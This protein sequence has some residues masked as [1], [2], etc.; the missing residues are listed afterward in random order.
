MILSGLC[1]RFLVLLCI[2]DQGRGIQHERFLERFF[3]L[4]TC[5]LH[6]SGHATYTICCNRH[7]IFAIHPSS[8]IIHQS[9]IR[10][11]LPASIPATL[12]THPLAQCSLKALPLAPRPLL[13][14][15]LPIF[16][17]L[18]PP[19]LVL[20]VSYVPVLRRVGNRPIRCGRFSDNRN[21]RDAGGCGAVAGRCGCGEAG[22]GN[23]GFG[24]CLSLRHAEH[25]PADA[26]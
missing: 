14:Q 19:P 1:I 11:P 17:K 6:P 9:P 25:V 3:F 26:H 20:L 18:L 12:N 8:S 22:G 15:I 21:E 10:A 7:L 2:S 23:E 4:S 24:L 5:R 13:Q 16:F